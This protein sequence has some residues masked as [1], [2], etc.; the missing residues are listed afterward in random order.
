MRTAVAESYVATVARNVIERYGPQCPGLRIGDLCRAMGGI[1]KITKRRQLKWCG[2]GIAVHACGKVGIFVDPYYDEERR[3]WI[4]AHELGHV[5]LGHIGTWTTSAGEKIP[6]RQC[7]EQ[8]AE[9]FAGELL[10]LIDTSL[11]NSVL[12]TSNKWEG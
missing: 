4:A 9:A 7:D 6:A 1:A 3:R 11:N 8:E 12:T 2:G 5:V 10:Q